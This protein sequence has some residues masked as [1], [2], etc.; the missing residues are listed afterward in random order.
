MTS[1]RKKNRIIEEQTMFSYCASRILVQPNFRRYY[2]YFL[3][4]QAQTHLDYFN[5]LDKLCGKI[6]FKSDNG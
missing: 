1:S 4:D 2:F 3:P 5:V 6:S